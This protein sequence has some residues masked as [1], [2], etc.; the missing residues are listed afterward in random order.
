[1]ERQQP[2]AAELVDY[3][4]TALDGYEYLQLPTDHPRPVLES[5]RGSIRR[6][7]LGERIAA[8]VRALSKRQGTTPFV[9]LLA[10]LQAELAR[11]TGQRDIVVGVPSANR[12]RSSLQPL[13]GFLVN[14]LP[15]RADLSGDPTF[16]QLLDRLR[17]T[18]VAGYAHQELPFAKLVEAIGVARDHGRSPVFNVLFTGAEAPGE[19][20]A[21]GLSMRLERIDLLAAKFDLAFFAEFC[22]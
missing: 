10:A 13:V 12:G 7:L 3:W 1:W 6:H 22:S 11:Y 9:V 4:R 21:A 18:T 2:A 14:T 16:L 20:P 15:I 5:F 19:V 17:R 8:D